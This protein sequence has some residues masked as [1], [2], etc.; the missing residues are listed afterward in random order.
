[1]K[2][3]LQIIRMMS[4]ST[5]DTQVQGGDQTETAVSTR[6]SSAEKGLATGTQDE[7]Q[8]RSKTDMGEE[9][10]RDTAARW[11]LIGLSTAL[12]VAGM[13]T[14]FQRQITFLDAVILTNRKFE[15]AER[16]WC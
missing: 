3:V 8:A 9:G 14:G 7:T 13:V 4:K 10:E 12:T 1:M 11:A 16:T 6:T 15:L 5:P 2:G